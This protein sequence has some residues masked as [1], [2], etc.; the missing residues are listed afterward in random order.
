MV[1]RAGATA[2]A[3]ST[4]FDGAWNVTLVFPAHSG[5]DDA[6]G[7][8]HPFETQGI[9]GELSA[10]RGTEGES[11]WHHLRAPIGTG[12]RVASARSLQP[13]IAEPP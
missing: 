3:R 1:A 4:R 12:D 13:L 8:P 6:E 10:T 9:D 11:G 2:L 7:R 5:R